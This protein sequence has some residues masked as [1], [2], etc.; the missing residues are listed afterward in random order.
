MRLASAAKVAGVVEGKKTIMCTGQENE[1]WGRIWSFPLRLSSAFE[2]YSD[3]ALA[4]VT[5]KSLGVPS[6]K[7]RIRDCNDSRHV[8][9]IAAP[10]ILASPQLP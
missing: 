6:Q 2:G 7:G 9:R 1:I 10:L 8:K 5:G 4:L 3:A